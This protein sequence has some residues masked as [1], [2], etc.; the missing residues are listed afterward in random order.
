[1]IVLLLALTGAANVGIEKFRNPEAQAAPDLG[2]IPHRIGEWESRGD[3]EME[4]HVLDILKPDAYVTRDYKAPSG[5]RIYLFAQF[6]GTNRWGAHQPEVC[7]TSQGWTI[8]YE[9]LTSTIQKELPGTEVTANRFLAHRGNSTQIVLYW[10]F[11]SGNFQSASRTEQMLSALKTQLL[12]G[13][14]G[15]N[16]FVEVSMQVRPG[17]QVEDEERLRR[18]AGK[19]VPLI[20]AVIEARDQASS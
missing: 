13:K 16:G 20:R 7:F 4:P 18:F 11:S 15:G 2:A 14:G 19:L 1:L 10:W 6:H 17:Q 5:E 3:L 9:K 8:E 12:T